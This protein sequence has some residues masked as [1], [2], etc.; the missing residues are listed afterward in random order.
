M[1]LDDKSTEDFYAFLKKYTKYS[2]PYI[3]FSE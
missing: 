2:S 3:I 1:Y